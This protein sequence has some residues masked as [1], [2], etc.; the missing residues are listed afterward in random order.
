MAT[1]FQQV[2]NW[3]CTTLGSDAT[4]LSAGLTGVWMYQAPEGIGY[5]FIV[6]EKN[7][8]DSKHTFGGAAMIKHFVSVKT[9]DNAVVS[10]GGERARLMQDRVRELLDCAEITGITTG[11]PM[12]IRSYQDYEM[13]D[14]ESGQMS[15]FMAAGLY[16]VTLGDS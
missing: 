10:D 2:I 12:Y 16:E 13:T 7:V 11:Y 6:I 14:F 1:S 9:V 8:A 15:F 4:L 3:M 5:P